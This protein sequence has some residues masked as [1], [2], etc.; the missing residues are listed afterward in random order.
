MSFLI[1]VAVITIYWWLR[2]RRKPKLSP[3]M[4]ER[5]LKITDPIPLCGKPDVVW[6][7]RDG[8]LIVGDYKSRENQQVYES[9]VIQLSVYKLLIEKTQNKP[10]ADYGFIHF[11]NRYMKKVYLKKETEIISLYHSYW[12]V[13]N[14]EVEACVANNENYCQYC[15]HKHKC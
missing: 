11:K 6:K 2:S 9:E 15:S 5:F 8:T 12:D 13:V 3:Y 14:G 7:A 1:V 4:L 10:V